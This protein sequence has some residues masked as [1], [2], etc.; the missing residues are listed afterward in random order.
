[1]K[2]IISP[3]LIRDFLAGKCTAEEAAF[4]RKWYD[5]FEQEAEPMS[6]LSPEERT[7]LKEMMYNEV[8]QRLRMHNALPRPTLFSTRRRPVFLG[9]AAAALLLLI[10]L[11]VLLDRPVVPAE[12][13][14]PGE[15]NAGEIVQKEEAR[16]VLVENT[17]K[18][19]LRQTLSDG[20]V[21]WLKPE[22]WISFPSEF[23]VDKREVSMSGEAFFEVSP[24]VSRPFTVYSG[25][26]VTRVLGTSFNI[27]AFK[28][29]PSAEV[30]VFTGQ[31]SVSLPSQS[32]KGGKEE[33]L[34]V[35]DEKAVFLQSEKQLKK[36]PYST[37]KQPELNIWKKNTISFNDAPVSQ[38]VKV[39]NEEFDVSLKVAETD[40]ELN[41][42]ILKADFTNQ[43]LPD[44][45]QMLEK[46][47]SLTYEMK[48]KEIILKL[49]I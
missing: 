48:G 21:V 26:L 49:D 39:L 20:S 43:N 42:Y 3:E 32:D 25:D 15:K 8:M 16:E 4:V 35:K 18:T 6:V 5:S 13:S 29:G 41:N 40:K 19:I 1:M 14:S 38:V 45:L 46:S 44:I 33:L 27:K 28:N 24:D 37:K 10:A 12:F 11:G 34:L 17:C 2:R 30:S 23:A 22:T 31:V 9:A 47:L 7:S 36:Q